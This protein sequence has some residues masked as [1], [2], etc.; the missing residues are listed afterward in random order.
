MFCPRCGTENAKGNRYCVG[1]GADLPDSTERTAAAA[2]KVSFRQR[3]D[4]LIGTGPRARLLTA[5]TALAIL[6]A[7]VAFIALAPGDEDSGDDAYTRS[8]D[9]SC[10][11]EKQTIAALE[12]QT[13]QQAAGVGTFAGALVTIV[14]EWRSRLQDPPPPAADAE[15][16]DA[17]DSALLDVVIE[18]GGLARVASSGNPQ[19]IAAAAGRIDNASAQV[20]RAIENAGLSRCADLNVAIAAAG[21]Q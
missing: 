20:E 21:S 3:L 16:V 15:A 13:A 14:E 1:C 9:Q 11:T 19:Q 2:T 8:L 6:V 17:L 7:V 10:L 4:R 18:A 5:A 12:R